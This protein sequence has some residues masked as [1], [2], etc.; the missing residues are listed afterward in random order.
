VTF[1]EMPGAPLPTQ[2]H[3]PKRD[4]MGVMRPTPEN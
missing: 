4:E 2:A 3:P 1:A